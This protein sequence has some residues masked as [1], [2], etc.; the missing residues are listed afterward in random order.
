MLEN[1]TDAVGEHEPVLAHFVGVGQ[2]PGVDVELIAML[3]CFQLGKWA[4]LV[5]CI[6]YVAGQDGA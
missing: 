1:C 2:A 6:P 5:P 4:G 3:E